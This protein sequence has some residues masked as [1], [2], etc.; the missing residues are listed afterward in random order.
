MVVKNNAGSKKLNTLAAKINHSHEECISSLRASVSHARR[1]GNFLLEAQALVEKARE[2]WIPWVQDHC[3]FSVSEAQRYMRIANRY[4]ELSKKC[5]DPRALTITEALRLLSAGK[6]KSKD[7][8]KCKPFAVS[9]NH[10]LK[11][12]TYNAGDIELPE[13]SREAKFVETKTDWLA[14]QIIQLANK[15]NLTDHGGKKVDPV[16]V[17]IALIQRLKKALDVSK[18]VAVQEKAASDSNGYKPHN[19]I[20]GSAKMPA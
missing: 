1:T 18:V 2:K 9:S 12:R 13:E 6:N 5:A 7:G 10:E 16:D 15:T 14:E 17:A 20:N 8:E 4:S 3:D 19:R 11:E